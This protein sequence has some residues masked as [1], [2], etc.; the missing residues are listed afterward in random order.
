MTALTGPPRA[1][2]PDLWTGPRVGAG[3]RRR[4]ELG[5]VD[6]Q[7]ERFCAVDPYFYDALTSARPEATWFA[8]ARRPVPHGWQRDALDDWL[9]YGPSPPRHQREVHHGLPARRRRSGDRLQRP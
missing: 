8:A 5:T 4:G 3:P 2:R 6:R 9:V 1:P 7:Y